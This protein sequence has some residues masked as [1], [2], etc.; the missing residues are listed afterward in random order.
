MI[1]IETI[2]KMHFAILFSLVH[3]KFKVYNSISQHSTLPSSPSNKRQNTDHN[4]AFLI[5]N[6][7]RMG[8]YQSAGWHWAIFFGQQC[9]CPFS[10]VTE[11]DLQ[12][13]KSQHQS[14]ELCACVSL[15]TTHNK[16]W[17]FHFAVQLSD[18]SVFK[19]DFYLFFFCLDAVSLKSL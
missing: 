15:H 16:S 3:V 14:L 13:M 7:S 19:F 10:W 9:L 6:N 18:F 4:L 2:M 5:I 8:Q 11:T 12:L 17:H 1:T